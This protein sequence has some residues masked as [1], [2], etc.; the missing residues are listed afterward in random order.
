MAAA[1]AASLL[2]L[3]STQRPPPTPSAA[4]AI[5]LLR[6]LAKTAPAAPA[7][8]Q[9]EGTVDDKLLEEFLAKLGEMW[10]FEDSV[11]CLGDGLKLLNETKRQE[12][13]QRA[14]Q[15]VAFRL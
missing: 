10:D 7:G 13:L 4:A 3:S 9:E 12:T 6:P 14:F 2:G 5:D 11:F 1:A 8:G 15:K